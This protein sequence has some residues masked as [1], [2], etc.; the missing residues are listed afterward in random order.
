MTYQSSSKNIFN[1]YNS[2]DSKKIPI[3]LLFVNLAPLKLRTK[4]I[5]AWSLLKQ[6]IYNH[7]IFFFLRD[8]IQMQVL[9][10]HAYSPL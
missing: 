8:T 2:R 3:D 4:H 6:K 9:I 7:L 5:L 1:F 10:I